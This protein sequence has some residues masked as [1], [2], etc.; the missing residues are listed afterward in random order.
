MDK[1]NYDIFLKNDICG[2]DAN[3]H[4]E[5]LKKRAKDTLNKS[6]SE[7]GYVVDESTKYEIEIKR[8]CTEFVG[9]LVKVRA[10]REVV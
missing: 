3:L 6:L 10:K 1:Q 7:G 5:I 8:N 4:D 2:A 9:T